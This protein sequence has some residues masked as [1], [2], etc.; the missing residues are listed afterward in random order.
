MTTAARAHHPAAPR[1][2]EPIEIWS[3]FAEAWCA[4]FEVASTE[5]SHGG[6]RYWV[7][8]TNDGTVLPVPIERDHVRHLAD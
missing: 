2:F 6:V 1:G 4:G 5:R 3:T 8:R 7:R